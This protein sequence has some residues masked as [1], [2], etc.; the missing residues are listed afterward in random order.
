MKPSLNVHGSLEMLTHVHR[1]R[2]MTK[3]NCIW[4][5][6]SYILQKLNFKFRLYKR[7]QYRDQI[8]STCFWLDF[9]KRPSLFISGSGGGPSCAL[10][11]ASRSVFGDFRTSGKNSKLGLWARLVFGHPNEIQKK[12]KSLHQMQPLEVP[13]FKS[14]YGGQQVNL[15]QTKVILTPPPTVLWSLIP[16]S[17]IRKLRLMNSQLCLVRV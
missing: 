12:K 3:R 15:Y 9:L 5:V 13:T 4:V 7:K 16:W 17:H 1:L 14:L 8:A 11:C 10:A 2:K 6:S